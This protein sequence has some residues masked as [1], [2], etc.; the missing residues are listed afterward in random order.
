MMNPV[1]ER[2]LETRVVNNGSE[3][4][5][6]HHPEFPE[7][8]SHVGRSTGDLLQRAV[9]AVQ[10]RV[11][12]E[13]G[14][15]YGVST[16]F[17]CDALSALPR[18]GVHIVLDPFQNA[19]WRG[20]G[21]RNIEEAGFRDL[22]EFHEERSEIFLPRM[23]AEDRR[24]DFVFIDGLHRYDQVLM[25]F[26]YVNRL[27]RPGGIVLFDDAARPSVKRVVRHALSYPCYET[28]GAT[29]AAAAVPSALGRLRAKAGQLS[30]VR[31]LV[32]PDVL[33]RDWDL[34]VLG[35]CVGLRKISEDERPHHWDADF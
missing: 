24:V 34:G 4:I 16:L 28:F 7:K 35:R 19:K 31:Q 3:T 20:I 29:E 15:A 5:T 17:I 12:L 30:T 8:L 9:A 10:P 27:L 11:S 18:P 21:L 2:I 6:L 25:E 1:L 23:V 33:V 26:Y 32:R 13:I 22:V 14:L